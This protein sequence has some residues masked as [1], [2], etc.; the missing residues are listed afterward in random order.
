MSPLIFKPHIFSF[1]FFFLTTS[2]WSQ[3]EN[4]QSYFLNQLE[5]ARA[6]K[7]FKK[8]AEVYFDFGI[9]EDAENRNP[10]KSFEYLSRAWEYFKVIND[11]VRIYDSKYY[12][13]NHMLKNSMYSD[14]QKEYT[15]LKSYYNSIGDDKRSAEIELKLFDLHLEKLN[16]QDAKN[17]LEVTR[18]Y[19]DRIGRS[20]L[21]VDYLIN[22]I[23]YYEFVEE[24]DTALIL[25]NQC[26][27][28]TKHEANKFD[29][30]ICLAKRGDIHLK[31]GN[32]YKAI[33]DYNLVVPILETIPY[34]TSLLKVYKNIS[35]CY[36]EMTNFRAANYFL[37][38]YSLLQDSILNENRIIAVNN[39][40]YKHESEE[41]SKDIVLLEK[42]K[43]FA[44]RSNAQQRRA[45][46]VLGIALGVLLLGFYYLIRFYRDKINTAKIIEVQNDKISQ[47]KIKELQDEIQI[48]SMQSMLTGQ[49]L[50]RER[51]AKDL[52]DSLGGLL[53]TIKLQVDNISAKE[54]NVNMIP[55]YKKATNLLD[56]AVS[57]VRSISQNL[58]P[59]ALSSL[60]LIPAIRDLIN[61]YDSE[62]GP[63]IVFQHFDIPAKMDQ[64]VALG[65]YRI[66]QEILN[67]A[68]K[69]SEAKEV[70]IQ[71]NKE[72]DDIIIHIE[73]D[74]IGF[75]TSKK[76]K[77][78]GLENIKSRVNYLK[79][80]IEIDSRA[81][82]GTSFLI[83][84][85]YLLD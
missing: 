67:N 35:T 43:A 79:G 20:N 85:N 24:I 38:K 55:E 41:K 81:N 13:A 25:A 47:Q 63:E 33:S 48:N 64:S 30:A 5:D 7:D 12:I 56:T 45:L 27:E 16:I 49:E 69:H 9:F 36:N 18:N 23:K 68:L 60:G 2:A 28:I 22:K 17:A 37:N 26:F 40:T 84:V 58:Q 70:L 80:T 21:E 32:Y 29:K 65:I 52:H 54:S 3:K 4:T 1:L 42:D 82:E 83:H 71:L 44:Q 61:R 62:N 59:G 77:S 57:E 51:I 78:M 8:L 39:L 53:S 19:L 34:S 72:N 76:Y 73:D 74:G 31:M 15:E 75:D 46:S 50:E 10:E 66:V 11:T 6:S 14:A